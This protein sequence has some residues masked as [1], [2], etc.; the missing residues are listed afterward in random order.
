[1]SDRPLMLSQQTTGI[2]D[3]G[4]DRSSSPRPVVVWPPQRS[5][6]IVGWSGEKGGEMVVAEL[7]VMAA[8]TLVQ[9]MVTDGWEGV[10]RKV[11]RLFGRG[12]PGWR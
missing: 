12:Q 7:A 11:A 9:A 5:R 3:R 2:C 1:M 6:A 8:N 4:R 10:R